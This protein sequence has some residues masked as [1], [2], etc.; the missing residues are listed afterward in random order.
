MNRNKLYSLLAI[1][2]VLGIAWLTVQYSN[3]RTLDETNESVCLIKQTTGIP[4]PSCGSTRSMVELLDGNFMSSLQW[5]PFG[6]LILPVM[7]ISPFWIAADMIS[8][9]NSLFRFYQLVERKFSTK[10]FAIPAIALVLANW[11]WN[12]FKHL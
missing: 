6:W 1:T 5:N 11:I 4:C 2:C 7:L 8:G 12:I 3:H 10:W 9:R